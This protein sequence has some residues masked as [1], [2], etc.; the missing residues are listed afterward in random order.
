M[1]S[2]AVRS[3]SDPDDY[4]AWIRNA[5][6][7]MTITGCGQLDAK[8]IRIDLHRL[9]MQ[10]FSDNLPR[11]AHSD[12]VGRASFTFR[13]KPGP[14]LFW[15]DAEMLPTTIVRHGLGESAFQRSGGSA[16]WGALSL[17]T[18]D[19]AAICGSDLT[20]PSDAM[21]VTPAPA[22]MARLQRLHA[23]A[24]YLAE[25][26]PELIANPHSAR[27]LEQALI[28]ALVDC[29]DDRQKRASDVAQG[30]HA[31]VMRRFRK[32]LEENPEHPFY[33]PEMAKKIRVSQRSLRACCQEYL[34]MSPKRYLLLR[35][36][37]LVRG[38]LRAARSD[39]VTVTDVAMRYGFWQLGRFAV[40]YR[41]L[42]GEAP[43]ATLQ[44]Q[45]DVLSILPK[46][47]STNDHRV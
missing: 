45:P 36:M 33:I 46:L 17:P 2:S 14:S 3:F 32:V 8:I 40:G 18:D 28:E 27:G 12:Q 23:A 43:S 1:P 20:P 26:A 39:T 19:I 24:G 16:H 47:H 41:S 4:A 13:T 30:Q 22:A 21:S 5:K 34:G 42:F 11:V 44:H 6:V 15:G 35:R 25:E 29:L 10:R 7:E 9:W 38:A 37:N 31:I